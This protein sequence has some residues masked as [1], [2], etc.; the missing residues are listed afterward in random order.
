MLD[1]PEEKY[2][3]IAAIQCIHCAVLLIISNVVLKRE[4]SR[5]TLEKERLK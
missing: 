4:F 5:L 3:E 2:I 1:V